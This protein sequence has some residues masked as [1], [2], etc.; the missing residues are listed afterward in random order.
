MT[1]IPEKALRARQRYSEGATTRDI[2][3]ETKLSHWALYFWLAGGPKKNG[4]RVLEPIVKRKLVTR[5][6]ILKEE[7]LHMVERMMRAAERQ[8]RE[9]EERLAGTKQEP[10]AT[11]RDARTLAVLA[12]TM[13]SLTALDAL[14]EPKAGKKKSRP[15]EHDDDEDRIPASIDALREE[16]SKK[17]AGMAAGS[18]GR[19]SVEIDE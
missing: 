17:L 1:D 12:R 13:Q 7:R 15:L 4:V 3:A 2:L 10:G 5:R 8:I 18:A 9:I 6:R 19:V 16:L 11:E 14:H